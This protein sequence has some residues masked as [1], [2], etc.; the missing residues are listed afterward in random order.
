MTVDQTVGRLVEVRIGS[1]VEI[2]E[3]L[4]LRAN[5]G[6]AMAP[7]EKV[8]FCV[9][10]RRADVFEPEVSER[11]LDVMRRDNPKFERSA[12]LTGTRAAF[13]LQLEE[14]INLSNNPNRK[15]FQ[16]PSDLKAWLDP[17]MTQAEKDR[18]TQFMNET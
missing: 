13:A 1:P 6:K 5:L 11:F 7:H 10:W 9:D 3:F 12:F 15:A 16:S 8:L 4:H 14:M 18:I 17:L 2:H